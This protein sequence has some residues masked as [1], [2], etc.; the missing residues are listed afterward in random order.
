[1]ARFLRERFATTRRYRRGFLWSECCKI[2]L[3][4]FYRQPRHCRRIVCSASAAATTATCVSAS[5]AA[6]AA[7]ASI[8]AA[9]TTIVAAASGVG[10]DGQEVDEGSDPVLRPAAEVIVVEQE[11]AARA[12]GRSDA[13]NA[14]VHSAP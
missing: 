9:T 6:A 10:C 2:P 7:I 12:H 8:V 5:A 11:E 3:L 4:R 14:P 13:L 1:M